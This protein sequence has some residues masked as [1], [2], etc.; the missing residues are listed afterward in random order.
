MTTRR[1]DFDTTTRGRDSGPDSPD[2]G[3]LRGLISRHRP[4][5]LVA[6]MVALVLAGGAFYSSR[7]SEKAPK[8]VYSFSLQ[9]VADEAQAPL[10]VNLN[11]AD[12]E[13]LDELPEIGPSTAKAIIEYRRA[14]GS[15]RS[16]DE[17]EEVSGIGPAT[18]EEIKPFATV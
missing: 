7:V 6:C 17:L 14:N 13:Q 4:R 1:D 12:E 11:S 15:F 2:T 18:L 5:I 8:V 16:V 10:L 3:F 9:E